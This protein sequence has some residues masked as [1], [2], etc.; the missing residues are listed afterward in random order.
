MAL[1]LA[2]VVPVFKWLPFSKSY[3]VLKFPQLHRMLWDAKA[4]NH[5]QSLGQ[6]MRSVKRIAFESLWAFLWL[7]IRSTSHDAP[8]ILLYH[9]LIPRPVNNE[10]V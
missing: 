3:V 8:A 9:L 6:W 2:R 4:V 5:L 1:L 7:K 10:V